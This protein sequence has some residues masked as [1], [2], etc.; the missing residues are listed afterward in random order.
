MSIPATSPE[1]Q[2]P[3]ERLVCRILAAQQK[4]PA[5]DTSAMEREIDQQVYALYALTREEIKIVEDATK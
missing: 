3:M 5:A 1:K 2:K 4:H